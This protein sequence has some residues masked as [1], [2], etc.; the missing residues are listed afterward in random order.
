METYQLK[1]KLVESNREYLIRTSNDTTSSAISSEVFINGELAESIKHLH[2][3]EFTE[4]DV[5]ALLKQTHS[6]K[7]RSIENLM[8]AFQ[9][10]MQDNNPESLVHLGI[11]FYCMQYLPEAEELFKKALSSRSDFDRAQFYLSKTYLDWGYSEQAVS[12]AKMTV[13]KC[14]TYADYHNNFGL[15][16]QAIKENAKAITEFEEA[17]KL[18]L[19]YGEAYFN[20][21]IVW[22][23]TV[24]SGR[25]MDAVTDTIPLIMDCFNKAMLVIPDIDK[26]LFEKGLAILESGGLV[27]AKD[28]FI[29]VQKA[30][31]KKY[32]KDLSRLNMKYILDSG[33]ISIPALEEQ[34]SYL[35][36]QVIKNPSFVDVSAD[37]SQYYLEIAGLYWKKG[38]DQ[39]IQTRKLN[40]NLKKAVLGSEQAEKIHR[41]ISHTLKILSEKG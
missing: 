19:Y 26:P 6:E 10:A 2:P 16:L 34:I 15:T 21:G 28:I 14:P 35:E 32:R 13:D 1:S 24:I 11:T 41:D 12:Y 37:L 36:H 5:I 27:D 38:L 31:V 23:D 8:A 3:S 22:I 17:I 40:P 9:T 25:S 20:M 30:I 7:K 4:D 18:N 33:L 39:F 29:K